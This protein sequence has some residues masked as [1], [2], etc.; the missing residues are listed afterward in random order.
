MKR[1]LILLLIG[2]ITSCIGQEKKEEVKEEQA[3]TPQGQWKVHREY[4]QDGNL[5]R[6]DSIY[7]WSYSAQNGESLTIN[8][9]SIMDEFRGYFNEETPYKWKKDFSYFPDA[10]SLF[11]KDF[12]TDDYFFR[13]WQEHQDEIEK[14][15]KKMDSS[16]NAFL[17]KYHPGLIDSG[18][19]DD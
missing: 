3:E 13:N 4:D 14:M 10:D 19:E 17:R 18:K 7:S 11:M 6:Y 15:I 5:I 8:L 1:L 9:D 12:F 2:M 16:R